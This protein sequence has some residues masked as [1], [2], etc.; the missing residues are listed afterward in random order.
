VPKQRDDRSPFALAV[1]WTSRITTI[2][3]E[4]V[5]PALGGFWLDQW[6]G[7][8]AVFLILGALFGFAAAMWQLIQLTKPPRKDG[9]DRSS[10]GKGG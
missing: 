1:E 4:M 9:E 10:R 6:L 3:L 2:A 7:T 8:Q 5:L